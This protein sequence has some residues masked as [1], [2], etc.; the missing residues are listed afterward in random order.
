MTNVIELHSVSK[1]YPKSSQFSLEDISFSI[2]K[3]EKLGV[4]GPNGAGKTTLMSILCRIIYQTSGDVNYTGLEGQSVTS[5]EFLNSIGFVPQDF[6]FYSELSPYQNLRYFGTLY[7]I[8][9]T[10]LVKRIEELMTVLGLHHVMH[11]KVETFSGGMKRRVNLA[12]GIINNPSILFLDEP[13][14]GVDVQSK[15]AIMA[16]LEEL[17]KKGTTIIYTSHHMNEAEE[18]CDNIALLDKGKLIVHDD[19]KSLIKEYNVNDLQ[20]LF[21]QLTG[22]EYRD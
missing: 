15:N 8:Q 2:K 21:L 4:F 13:T 22:I 5:K 1:K 3:G 19:L 10:E 14:V 20:A 6:S 17:N 12:I 11:N 9:K 7:G 18:F 16:Y